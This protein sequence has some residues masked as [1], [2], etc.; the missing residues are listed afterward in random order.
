MTSTTTTET[1]PELDMGPGA[2]YHVWRGYA[3]PRVAGIRKGQPVNKNG[4]ELIGVQPASFVLQQGYVYQPDGPHVPW[5]E[6][7]PVVANIFRATAKKRPQAG[8]TA[9]SR[10]TYRCPAPDG[11]CPFRTPRRELYVRH[12]LNAHGW[13]PEQLA[14]LEAHARGEPVEAP[15]EIDLGDFAHPWEIEEMM[16]AAPQAEGALDRE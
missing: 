3:D 10:Q 11:G 4:K 5:D 16:G 8:V 15:R 7:P 1:V 6:V 2:H 13:S 12:C 9:Q 14:Q